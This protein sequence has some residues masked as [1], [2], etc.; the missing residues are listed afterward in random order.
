MSKTHNTFLTDDPQKYF[1]ERRRVFASPVEKQKG[2][3]EKPTPEQIEARLKKGVDFNA[4]DYMD[5][6]NKLGEQGNMKPE[7]LRQQLLD[8]LI[9][10]D[11]LA[12]EEKDDKDKADKAINNLWTTIK[13]A[14]CKI[15]KMDK[16]GDEFH[17]Q[18]YQDSKEKIKGSTINAEMLEKSSGVPIGLAIDTGELAPEAEKTGKEGV[19]IGTEPETPENFAGHVRKVDKAAEDAD[20]EDIAL[21]QKGEAK[22]AQVL[23]GAETGRVTFKGA[24][25]FMETKISDIYPDAEEGDTVSI[26]PP[27]ASRAK[28]AIYESGEWHYKGNNKQKV[29]IGYNDELVWHANPDTH[30][31]TPEALEKKQPLG[32]MRMKQDATWGE[33][34]KTI[35]YTGEIPKGKLYETK[36]GPDK[37]VNPDSPMAVLKYLGYDPSNTEDINKY[38]QVLEENNQDPLYVFIIKPKQNDRAVAAKR[39]EF[40]AEK[41]KEAKK[42]AG[43]TAGQILAEERE[44]YN[45]HSDNLLE[46]KDIDVPQDLLPIVDNEALWNLYWAKGFAG[47]DKIKRGFEL[48][49]IDKVEKIRDVLLD[50]IT[51]GK[52]KYID[53]GDI[54]DASN[55]KECPIYKNYEG[56]PSSQSDFKEEFI[57]QSIAQRVATNIENN[58]NKYDSLDEAQIDH[59]EDYGDKYEKGVPEY[60]RGAKFNQLKTILTGASF[61]V[62]GLGDLKLRFNIDEAKGM[63]E[64]G[65]KTA[66][67]REEKREK[68]IRRFE[69]EPTINTPEEIFLQQFFN[70]GNTSAIEETPEERTGM[71]DFER[72][73]SEAAGYWAV[74]LNCSVNGKLDAKLVARELNYYITMAA[75]KYRTLYEEEETPE[76]MTEKERMKRR[77]QLEDIPTNDVDFMKKVMFKYKVTD[78]LQTSAV[79]LDGVRFMIQDGFLI[80]RENAET[81][82]GKLKAAPE[83][84]KWKNL[85]KILEGKDEMTQQIVTELATRFPQYTEEDLAKAAKTI[86][87]GIK[88]AKISTTNILDINAGANLNTG[89]FQLGVSK[90]FELPYGFSFGIGVAINLKDGQPMIGA[91]IGKSTDINEQWSTDVQAAIGLEPLTVKVGAGID[92]GFTWMSKGNATDA[93]RTKVG[94]GAGVGSSISFNLTDIYLGPYIRVE[95]GQIKDANRMYHNKMQA[96]MI[97]SG[98]LSVDNAPEV[99]KASLI[100]RLPNNTGAAL[101]ELQV[102]LKWTDAQLVDFYEKQLKDTMKFAAM[103]F[104]SES[105]GEAGSISEWGIGVNIDAAKIATFIVLAT[106]F[107]WLIPVLAVAMFGKLGVVVGNKITLKQ[108][109]KG[110]KSQAQKEAEEAMIEELESRY[111]GF[112]IEIGAQTFEEKNKLVSNEFSGD[113]LQRITK[114]EQP[115]QMEVSTFKPEA[116]EK[117]EAKKAEFA[118]N[119]LRLDIDEKTGMYSL[120]PTEV[121]DYQ[122]YA[123]PGL[124]AHHGVIL[125]DG[126]ILVATS[127]NLTQLFIKRFDYLYP[128]EVEGTNLHTLITI[129]DNPNVSMGTIVEASD[130]YIESVGGAKTFARNSLRTEVAGKKREKQNT[131]YRYER[132][133]EL[134]KRDK[135]DY[136]GSFYTSKTPTPE[137]GKKIK[138]Q[139][140]LKAN[141][142]LS[143]SAF[144][145]IKELDKKISLAGLKM[146]PEQFEKSPKYHV[147]YRQLST[148]TNPDNLAKIDALIRQENP[149]ITEDQLILYKEELFRLSMSETN[150]ALREATIEQRLQWAEQVIYVPKFR[151][152]LKKLDPPPS[153]AITAEKLAKVFIDDIRQNLKKESRPVALGEDVITSVATAGVHGEREVGP[154]TGELEKNNVV[155][156]YD[157][158]KFLSVKGAAISE[159]QR[160][161]ARLLLEDHSELPDDNKNFLKSR[162]AKK[163]FYMCKEGEVPNPLISVLGESDFKSLLEVYKNIENPETMAS[164]VPAIDHFRSVCNKVREAQLGDGLP[165]KIDGNDAMAVHIKDYYFVVKTS[166]KSGIY[167]RCSNPSSFYNEEIFVY[168]PEQL[169]EYP[170][171]EGGVVSEAR[172]VTTLTDAELVISTIGLNAIAKYEIRPESRPPEHGHKPPHR[173]PRFPVKPTPE[174]ERGRGAKEL[175]GFTGGGSTE[176]PP[177]DTGGTGEAGV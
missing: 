140:N 164:N 10:N 84:G 30:K 144:K 37:E 93:W 128:R 117:F 3:A 25:E 103:K 81:E 169:R 45:R 70:P 57:Y 92:G 108:E 172:D 66:E 32:Y 122:L 157:Y 166:M 79:N 142:E 105:Y 119:H 69:T 47:K 80:T 83:L 106:L 161:I 62:E 165:V 127:E 175:G 61:L 115:A 22:R 15:V 137:T 146:S 35:M 104:V 109:L 19:P 118:Q 76:T 171:I 85:S 74:K 7:E 95:A 51:Q 16:A 72:K 120:E 6:L 131:I 2:E 20:A 1:A 58:K 5:T 14:G 100:R 130:Y 121:Q 38:A 27:G 159:E 96:D 87:K 60:A 145:T 18:F 132:L 67:V 99:E 36:T 163:L 55:H 73:S 46:N 129:S 111:P 141:I 48:M 53:F 42:R 78:N 152:K 177:E 13:D 136:F 151:E 68:G 65:E 52:D 126:K 82:G 125:K 64:K 155:E 143:D 147:T 173:P 112:K 49:G 43:E 41:R 107:P 11:Q 26:K 154:S 110:P 97:R 28:T 138:E 94:F 77:Y 89:K 24:K 156:A 59:Y 8:C 9:I 162:L 44:I 91:V 174:P 88:E 116:A 139:E 133:Q 102:N 40:K 134:G 34:A 23:A 158:A 135:K 63:L 149:D 150:A 90:T 4:G 167:E 170:G 39:E 168:K 12:L 29:V 123:D 86:E 148:N 75:I 71:T 114:R 113:Q 21:S 17:M 98:Y 153:A 56:K 124:P 33:I 176:G 101:T 54:L 50:A 160:T 31:P